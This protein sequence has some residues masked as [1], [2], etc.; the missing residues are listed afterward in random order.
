MT[1][2]ELLE[3]L[4]GFDDDQY[5]YINLHSDDFR[6]GCQV[7]IQGI[8]AQ[9]PW[10]GGAEDGSDHLIGLV[11]HA[12]NRLLAPEAVGAQEQVHRVF[13][14]ILE[15]LKRRATEA[16]RDHAVTGSPSGS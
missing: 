4:A 7:F 3:A 6:H 8:K 1:K 9:P 15:A 12:G 2:R 10:G 13:T 16:G 5:I 14:K 11:A